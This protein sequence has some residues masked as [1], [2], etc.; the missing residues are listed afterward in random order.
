MGRKVFQDYV[1]V[2]C[3]WTQEWLGLYDDLQLLSRR[4]HGHLSI[5]LVTGASTID[6]EAVPTLRFAQQCVDWLESQ[7]SSRQMDSGLISRAELIVKFVVE[8]TGED[9]DL[10][11]TANCQY[12]G[13]CVIVTPDREYYSGRTCTRRCGY[14]NPYALP[15][16]PTWER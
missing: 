16:E 13:R 14:M 15:G 6:G 11:L 10:L 12:S 9:D 5:D 7:L 4:H 2:L 3:S 1:N 8:L